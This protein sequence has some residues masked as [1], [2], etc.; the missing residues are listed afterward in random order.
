MLELARAQGEA[1]L[2]EFATFCGEVTRFLAFKGFS[3]PAGATWDLVLKQP[4]QLPNLAR[5]HSLWAGVNLG[6][7]PTSIV[8]LNLTPEDILPAHDSPIMTLGDWTAF[9]QKH[10][11][12]YPLVQVRIEPGEGYL[13]PTSGL[14]LDGSTVDAR[15]PTMSL[16][17]YADQHNHTFRNRSRGR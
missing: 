3:A 1:K 11:P 12:D 13:L 16:M 7:E 14:P 5:G 10:D 2:E 15:E 9:F 17:L 8:F 4:G 6:D